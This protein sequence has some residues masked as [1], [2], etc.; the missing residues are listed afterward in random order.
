MD[1]PWTRALAKSMGQAPP[2][3]PTQGAGTGRGRSQHRE[4]LGDSDADRGCDSVSIHEETACSSQEKPRRVYSAKG[5]ISRVGTG[6]GRHRCWG[7]HSGTPPPPAR[8]MQGT[9]GNRPSVQG[10]EPTRGDP[11]RAPAPEGL[12]LLPAPP[13]PRRLPGPSE[14]SSFP[15]PAPPLVLRLL[16]FP[17][18]LRSMWCSRLRIWCGCTCGTGHNCDLGSIPGLG[19][20]IGCGRSQKKKNHKTVHCRSSSCGSMG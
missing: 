1:Q 19:T 10:S 17:S 15:P 7:P 6:C 11:S 5:P 2:S 9:G 18:E 8:G 4:G 3:L 16:T 14:G 12:L 20:F 13:T